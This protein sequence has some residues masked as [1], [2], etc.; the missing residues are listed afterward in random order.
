MVQPAT[1]NTIYLRSYMFSSFYSQ[2]WYWE[3][4]I[5]ENRGVTYDNII[6]PQMAMWNEKKNASAQVA[7]FMKKGINGGTVSF[8]T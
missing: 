4:A 7:A 2:C 8:E 3:C 5:I 1:I 6:Q